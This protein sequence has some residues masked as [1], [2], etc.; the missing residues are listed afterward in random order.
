MLQAYIWR[1][2]SRWDVIVNINIDF[3]VIFSVSQY[4]ITL[5]LPQINICS[6]L[7]T[8]I[9]RLLNSVPLNSSKYNT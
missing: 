5:D 7:F 9:M 4:D 3:I 8:P 6:A 2:E 1:H